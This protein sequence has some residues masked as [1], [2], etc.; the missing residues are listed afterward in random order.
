MTKQWIIENR[1]ELFTLGNG[2]LGVR[3]DLTD[4]GAYINGFYEKGKITYGE[5]AYGFAEN[6]QTMITNPNGKELNIKLNSETILDSRGNFL[7]RDN[8]LN[9][10][11]SYALWKFKWESPNGGIVE[12]SVK[13]VVPFA[14]QGSVLY[15]W[16]LELPESGQT[17]EINSPLYLAI[18]EDHDHDDPRISAH[19]KSSSLNI[20]TSEDRV[21][22]HGSGSDLVSVS[23]TD[24]IIHGISDLKREKSEIT[25]GLNHKISGVASNRVKITKIVTYNYGHFS[26]RDNVE[27]QVTSELKSILNSNVNDVIT[28]QISFMDK[29]WN[30]S[31]VVIEGDSE[32][33][34][35]LRFNIFQLLQ[36]V[37]RDGKRS[38]AAKGLSGPGYE[39]HYFWDA[40]TYVLPFFIL[41]NP[42][43]AKSMLMYRISIIEQAQERA[44]VLG[45][46]GIL[47][48]WRTINGEESSAFF[49]AGTAQYHINA[50]IA[51][52]LDKYLSVTGD[53]SILD[54]GGDR[55]LEGTADFWCD[56]ASEIKGKGLCFNLVTGPDEY[57]ALVNNNYYTN[58]M[59][60]E[61]IL[62]AV[63]W[64]DG[65]ISPNKIKKWVG[66]ANNIY[67]PENV[68]II[69]QDDSFMT[70]E[71]WDFENTA[72]EKYPLLLNFH[73]LNIYR[74]QV[75]KQA[76]V[77]MAHALFKNSVSLGL[78]RRD[79]DFYEVLTTRD[80][81]LSACAQG[82]VAHWL[83][84]ED[85]SWEYFLETVHTDRMDIHKNVSH[86]LHTA[87]MGGS[88]LMI[89]LGFLGTE[90]YKN[91]LRFSP[92][93]PQALNKVE[94]S[95]YLKGHKVDIELTNEN[96]KYSILSGDVE[97]YHYSSL[98]KLKAG[99][100]I[101]MSS[102]PELK[103]TIEVGSELENDIYSLIKEKELVP[104]EVLLL[105]N[106]TNFEKI[107]GYGY[108]TLINNCGELDEK[109]NVLYN[110]TISF[111]GKRPKTR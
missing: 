15:L 70:K 98:I 67:I 22:V 96:I 78:M 72:D 110:K 39:G 69:P 65:K 77:V 80:S 99:E 5:K 71:P 83:G 42:A 24:H 46:S 107:S 58:L 91:T 21:L 9:L 8:I 64:L 33:Q 86:G 4:K 12:G 48:P 106:S 90:F 13:I 45:H 47:F 53:L 34:L 82:V 51:V 11:E 19:F 26:N 73:P 44:K 38:I 29:F 57:T 111:N 41:T 109:F 25:N 3:G 23:E 88:Y 14:Y 93:I 85:L 102:R 6:W 94:C 7:V 75:L 79:F 101:S 40:E 35:S 104:E 49:P 17:I 54:M 31:D 20:F 18:D 66:F 84:Y 68:D 37:G 30:N 55:L 87:S 16:D 108:K 62:A 52:G 100:S 105:T 27:K 10:K 63:K 36:S 76:D 56:F 81:S 32:A 103:L 89:V 59:A 50:D 74:K 61:N 97:F 95:I 92:K 43:I 28:D 1:C 2:F 60:K